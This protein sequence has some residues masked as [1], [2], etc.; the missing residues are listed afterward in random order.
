MLNPQRDAHR[1]ASC[2]LG[3]IPSHQQAARMAVATIIRQ[4]PPLDKLHAAAKEAL[5]WAPRREPQGPTEWYIYTDGSYNSN[6]PDTAAW[7]YVIIGQDAHGFFFYG[8]H[9]S[10]LDTSLGLNIDSIPSNVTSELAALAWATLTATQFDTS[11]MQVLHGLQTSN[12][13]N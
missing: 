4:E 6:S 10:R 2:K 5:I 13:K 11:A 7:A 12:H 1:T 9:A 8:Y 3:E